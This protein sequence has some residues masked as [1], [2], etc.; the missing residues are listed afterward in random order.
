[1]NTASSGARAVLNLLSRE[2]HVVTIGNFDGVHRGHQY[3]VSRVIEDAR[4]RATRSLIITF[5]PHPTS[6]LR[7]EMHFERLTSADAKL[8]LLRATGV[9]EVAVIP[10]DREFA[11]LEPREFLTLVAEAALLAAVFVGEGFRFGRKRSGD[12]EAIAAFGDERGFDTTIIARLRDDGAMISSSSIREALSHGDVEQAQ[13]YLGR[14]Y[15]LRGVVEHGAARGRELG[16]PTANL[17]LPD[18]CCVPGDGIYA[19]Y[20][21]ASSVG[22]G[23]R[24]AMVYIGT[25]PTFDGGVRMVEVNLLDFTGDLYTQQLEIEFVAFVRGDA[26]FESAEELAAQMQRDERDTR[27]LLSATDPEPWSFDGNVMTERGE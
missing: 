15:R 8:A 22:H 26:R 10:F 11:G 14:R 18:D 24:E 4:V 1:V 7:P 17:L 5:E 25:R 16:F 2:P 3:L 23:A 6:V 27:A 19:A 12:G 9:D 20:A 13:G 21:H